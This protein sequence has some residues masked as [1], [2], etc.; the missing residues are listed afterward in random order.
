[1]R[2]AESASGEFSSWEKLLIFILCSYASFSLLVYV[3]VK[4]LVDKIPATVPFK[5]LAIFG[6]FFVVFWVVLS[7][8]LCGKWYG[9]ITALLA[10]SMCLLV[11]PWFGVIKP[12]WFS[13]FGI[14][15]F[16]AL[17]ILTETTNGGFGNLACMLIN[18]GAAYA[19]H[20]AP[21]TLFGLITMSIAAFISGLVGD[22]I[23]RKVADIVSTAFLPK[24][25]EQEI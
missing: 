13:I 3:D 22:L 23:G 7:Y 4:S 5:S 12:D 15:S 16:F 2:S 17:G 21:V 9:V 20:V 10:V 25:I 14:I 19:F 1:M 6:G 18:W 8:R 24:K 11:S